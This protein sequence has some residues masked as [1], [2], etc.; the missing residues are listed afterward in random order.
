M[1]SNPKKL[2]NKTGNYVTGDQFWDREK[3]IASFMYHIGKGDH[4]IMVAQRRM[5]KTS[6]MKEISIRYKDEYTCIFV[7][8]EQCKDAPDAIKEL[9]LELRSFAFLWIH[10]KKLF[11]NI[12]SIFDNVDKVNI[13]ILKLKF[14]VALKAGNWSIKGDK[15]F[16]ILA[17]NKKPVLLL[18]DEVPIL[19]KRMLRGGDSKMTLD[20][21]AQADE[22]MSWLRKNSQEHQ[23]NVR[24]VLCGS[25]G[26]KQVLH[27]ANLSAVISH[28]VAFELEPWSNKTTVDCLHALANEYGVIFEEGVPAAMVKKLGCCIP[29][30]VQLFFS[31]VY[32]HCKHRNNMRVSKKDIKDIYN[33]EMII[34]QEKNGLIHYE[35]RLKKA[36]GN[37]QYKLA[38][39]MLSE[40][41]VLGELTHEALAALQKR[42][43]K[44]TDIAEI[45]EEI[46]SILLH[47]GYIK[48]GSKKDYVFVSNLLCDWWRKRYENSYTPVLSKKD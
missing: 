37:D 12:L 1:S 45:Q 2:K 26:L 21:I 31:C 19:V 18:L 36:L 3:E 38:K 35:E 32:D 29:H 30:H 11:A 33:N 24:I 44:I 40:A 23:D 16:K 14:S 13:N 6:L 42:F 48:E 22:F 8:F 20:R 27:Q 47:D 7:D 10:V 25:I 15:L 28:F 5:G 46:I 4:L 43:R 9:S 39:A 41:A 34:I 17:D